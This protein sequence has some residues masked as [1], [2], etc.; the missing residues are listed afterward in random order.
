M[1]SYLGKDKPTQPPP[2]DKSREKALFLQRWQGHRSYSQGSAFLRQWKHA[3]IWGVYTFLIQEITIAVVVHTV[4]VQCKVIH[5]SRKMNDK[6]G[7]MLSW[8]SWT[9]HSNDLRDR[10]EPS[11]TCSVLLM[12]CPCL[13]RKDYFEDVFIWAAFKSAY[14]T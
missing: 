12:K 13:K 2:R 11:G 5:N 3:F 6:F 7:S 1:D 8:K 14:L 10:Q 9:M 4:H